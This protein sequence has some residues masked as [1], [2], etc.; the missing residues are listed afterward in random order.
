MNEITLTVFS[1]WVNC[2]RSISLRFQG[3]KM[4]FHRENENHV[5]LSF[6]P[7][8]T[9]HCNIAYRRASHSVH[10]F[11][12]M[13]IIGF[14]SFFGEH[15][16]AKVLPWTSIHIVVFIS[17]ELLHCTAVDIKPLWELFCVFCGLSF[18]W[19][20][21]QN[22]FLRREWICIKQLNFWVSWWVV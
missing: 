22:P 17:F 6:S 9:S 2:S 7:S 19:A 3:E 4:N 18:F 12:G 8:E 10:L 5:I 15:Y 20:Y 14:F 1:S 16:I 21:M 13:Q 11:N